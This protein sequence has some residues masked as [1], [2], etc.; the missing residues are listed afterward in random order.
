MSDNKSYGWICPLCGIANAP[1]KGSC[2]CIGTITISTPTEPYSPNDW[3]QPNLYPWTTTIGDD[4][5]PYLTYEE[6]HY[7]GYEDEDEDVSTFGYDG[8]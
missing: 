4:G 7:D 8:I 5:Q 3:W 1:W 2:H 6:K